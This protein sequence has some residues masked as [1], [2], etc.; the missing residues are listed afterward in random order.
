MFDRIEIDPWRCGGTPV[1]KG[2]RIPVA[3]LPKVVKPVADREET[4]ACIV[5]ETTQELGQNS[6]L[7]ILTFRDKS[8]VELAI[9]NLGFSRP[10]VS[11]T[12]AT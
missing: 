8:K 5:L 12:I 6:P 2:T 4:I 3:V 7:S 10:R 9:G 11:V 1:I